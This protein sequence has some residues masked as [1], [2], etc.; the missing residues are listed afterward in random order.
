MAAKSERKDQIQLS[1]EEEV[2]I[3]FCVDILPRFSRAFDWQMIH[4]D[5]LVLQ[6]KS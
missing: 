4:I 2:I 5:P 1:K 3:P 6:L